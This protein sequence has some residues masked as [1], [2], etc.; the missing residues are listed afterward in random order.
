MAAAAFWV[1]ATLQAMAVESAS[2]L[3]VPGSFGFDAGKT[4][5]PGLYGSTAAFTYKG[6]IDL[7]ID[8]GTKSLDV[9]KRASYASI[10]VLYVPYAS[11]EGRGDGH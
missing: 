4:P 11:G 2:G 3:Y 1:A 9:D 10:A 8:G 5:E 7:H 6:H